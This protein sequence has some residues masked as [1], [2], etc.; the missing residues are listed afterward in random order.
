MELEWEP[1]WEDKFLL[2]PLGPLVLQVLQDLLDLWRPLSLV[3]LHFLENPLDLMNLL[4]PLGLQDLL[5]LKN[6]VCPLDLENPLDPL[7]QV[8]L[9]HRLGHKRP[10]YPVDQRH[11]VD[12]PYLVGRLNPQGQLVL[13]LPWDLEHLLDLLCLDFQLFLVVLLLLAILVLL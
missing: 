9:R 6:L 4:D 8:D 3:D 10:L 1:G 11:L 7:C 12:Q 13:L 5:D 2:D